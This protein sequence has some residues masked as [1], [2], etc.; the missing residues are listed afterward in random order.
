MRGTGLSALL[1]ALAAGTRHDSTGGHERDLFTAGGKRLEIAFLGHGTLMLDFDGTI[2]HV[3]PVP[4]Q[5]DYTQLPPADLVLVTHGHRDHLNP[6]LIAELLSDDGEVV[7]NPASREQ[8]DR[9]IGL[10]N[11]ESATVKG[12]GIT[13]VPAYNTT[14]ERAHHHPKGRDNGYLLDFAGFIVYVAGDTEPIPEMSEL[15]RVDVAFLP[16]NY[17]FTMTVTQATDAAHVISP[18]I[19]YPYH[20]GETRVSE[21]VKALEGESSIEVR[22]RSLA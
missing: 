16:V 4:E 15:G 7:A 12:I 11:G 17:P 19:L 22:L 20:Y 14:P 9:G 21:L 6:A 3:D 5:A 13:A 8:L 10:A 18:R 1:V 2:V